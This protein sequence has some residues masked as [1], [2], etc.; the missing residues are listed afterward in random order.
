MDT[1]I[2]KPDK[3]SLWY[4]GAVLIVAI[5]VTIGL[6]YYLSL[7]PKTE[8]EEDITAKLREAQRTK[9]L[10]QLEELEKQKEEIPPL[11]E[12]EIRK[13]LKELNKLH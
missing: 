4:L 13:Q 11:S 9:I 8:T 10:N 2:K 5:L 6:V 7:T 1:T 12:Q 3:K